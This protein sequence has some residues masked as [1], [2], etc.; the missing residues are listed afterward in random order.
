MQYRLLLI[1]QPIPGTY[2]HNGHIFWQ[3]CSQEILCSISL[4]YSTI[5]RYIMA[6]GSTPC[7]RK[8]TLYVAV[9]RARNSLELLSNEDSLPP[10]NISVTSPRLKLQQCSSHFSQS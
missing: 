9:L 8:V 5:T 7:M 10:L 6:M 2:F 4:I 1:L 3:S